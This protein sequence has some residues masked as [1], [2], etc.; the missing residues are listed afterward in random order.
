MEPFSQ[1]RNGTC[2]QA[3]TDELCQVVRVLNRLAQHLQPAQDLGNRFS[4]HVGPLATYD[5][6]FGRPLQSGSPA[7]LA[8]EPHPTVPV[9]YRCGYFVSFWASSAFLESVS[10]TFHIAYVNRGR[11]EERRVGKEC[12]S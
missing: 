1:R 4:F 3:R 5:A 8:R 7:R 10:Y 6:P 9:L 12:R 2:R 11:S